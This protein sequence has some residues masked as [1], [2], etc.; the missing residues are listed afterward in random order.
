M[1]FKY[2]AGT[3]EAGVWLFGRLHGAAFL[4]Y[5]GVAIIAARRLRCSP[6]FRRW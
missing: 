6:R 1:Y 3:T 2:V 5:V 4:L